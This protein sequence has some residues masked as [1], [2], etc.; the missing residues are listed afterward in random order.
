MIAACVTWLRQQVWTQ[1]MECHSCR[2]RTPGNLGCRPQGKRLSCC[3]QDGHRDEQRA[4]QTLR[5]VL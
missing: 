1:G 4:G 2:T 3:A 5:S